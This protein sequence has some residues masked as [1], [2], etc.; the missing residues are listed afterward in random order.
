MSAQTMSTVLFIIRATQIYLG[1]IQS[2][3]SVDITSGLIAHFDFNHPTQY[4][5]D[6]SANGNNAQNHGATP[7]VDRFNECCAMH[8]DRTS[9][10]EVSSPNNFPALMDGERT[11][12]AWFRMDVGGMVV[13]VG[14]NHL[15]SPYNE[16]WSFKPN[17]NVLFAGGN[18]NDLAFSNGS[19]YSTTTWYHVTV[20]KQGD[21]AHLYVNSTYVG[22]TASHVY[23]TGLSN[24]QN[25]L[26]GGWN[27]NKGDFGGDIDEVRIY[28]RTLSQLEINAVYASHTKSPTTAPSGAPTSPPSLAPTNAPTQP[29]SIAPSLAPTQPPSL[30]PT[31]APTKSPSATTMPPTTT[32]TFAPSLAPTKAPTSVPTTAPTASLTID[33]TADPTAP[34]SSDPTAD[35]TTDPSSSPTSAPIFSL[36]SL[37]IA[38]TADPTAPP[39]PDPTT[40]PTRSPL[41]IGGTGDPTTYPTMTTYLPTPDTSDPTALPTLDSSS[42]P[43]SPGQTLDPTKIPTWIPT[44]YPTHFPSPD[45]TTDP[46]PNPTIEPT[47]TPSFAPTW[48]PTADPTHFP[49]PDPTTNPSPDPTTD[50]TPNPTIEPTST[51]SF[52][53]TWIPTADPTHFP[54]PDPT[55][56]PSPDPTTD[57]TPNP[58][59]V[60]TTRSPTVFGQTRNP[61]NFPTISPT[62][63]PT[64]TTTAKPT[65]TPTR[66]PTS[67]PI[68]PTPHPTRLP[69]ISGQ[70][71]APTTSP[72]A[73]P[74]MSP[75]QSPTVA[76]TLSPSQGPTSSPVVPIDCIDEAI[77]LNELSV[78]L[79]VQIIAAR[80]EMKLVL[81]APQNRWFGIGFGA[82][83][84]N[85]TRAITVASDGSVIVV[86]P[87]GLGYHSAGDIMPNALDGVQAVV[88]GERRSITV[89]TSWT[90]DGLFDFSDFFDGKECE[91]SII[92]AVGRSEN[93]LQLTGHGA[94]RGSVVV[95]SCMCS[96]SPTANPIIAPS[97]APSTIP[98]TVTGS[99]TLEALESGA[100]SAQ[101]S[102]LSF[103]VMICFVMFSV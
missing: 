86:T 29:P 73:K 50:P 42:S 91:L 75:T 72:S 24:T 94:N 51:P 25:I 17:N 21:K 31:K 56:N 79:Y 19:T 9:Y 81:T 38:P 57:P 66:R 100:N 87:R 69:L 6:L 33:P 12:T 71:H 3:D 67:A 96:P 18:A 93:D 28:N 27:D 61:T 76:P 22:S 78:S 62:K 48:I 90:M 14:S 11:M 58:T 5:L 44:A 59:I 2:V 26:V 60:P 47:S 52:A 16:Q 68:I 55:T 89:E 70:T 20:T 43:S 10:L 46:T 92:Y 41:A 98:T 54:S 40:D 74:T 45:P 85:R 32:P 102:F 30:A 103:F 35:P 39:S 36:T 13:S 65:D 49:S 97:A 7:T 64:V 95:R 63:Q 15:Y 88:F 80:R 53:P 4:G 37:T 99:P 77:E 8:F 34:P 101:C 1:L 83:H 23:A 84:M 82:V